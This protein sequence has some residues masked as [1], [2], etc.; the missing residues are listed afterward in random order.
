MPRRATIWDADVIS[1]SD[2]PLSRRRDRRAAGNL[3]PGGAI[4]K[5]AAA[6][7]ELLVHRGKAV[8]FDSIEDFHERIDDPD[9]DV[10]ASSILVLRGCGPR[11]TPACRRWPT[12]RCRRSCSTRGARHGADLRRADERDGLRHGG[13]PRRSGSRGRRAARARADRRQILL[14]VPGRPLHLEV[15]DAELETRRGSAATAAGFARRPRLG[16]LYVDHVQQADTGVDLDF[17]V[18]ATG[19]GGLAGVA[20]IARLDTP[21]GPSV[22]RAARRAIRGRCPSALGELLALPLEASRAIVEKGGVADAVRVPSARRC[23]GDLAAGVTYRR[24][25]DG[26]IEESVDGGTP[27]DRVYD[28][29]RPELF[30]KATASRVV[31][32]GDPVGIR[33]DSGWDVPEPNSRWRSRAAARSSATS[34]QTT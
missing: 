4:I 19:S 8:V 16:K 6:S 21:K 7:P 9:L 15:S 28:A 33:A 17:L 2:Q 1:T 27:Y 5:P 14:D 18:G 24:S 11:A 13:A 22:G 32:D 25:R 34:W 20:L 12:C 10:E 26:R 30:L 3:A 23:P 29:A 31:T